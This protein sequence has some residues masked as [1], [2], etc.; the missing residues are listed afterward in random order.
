VTGFATEEDDDGKQHATFMR[1]PVKMPE[2]NCREWAALGAPV[3]MLLAC[4]SP[5][6]ASLDLMPLT[7][8]SSGSEVIMTVR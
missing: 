1:S 5:H 3:R 7:D 6:N 8:S 4:S 2:A